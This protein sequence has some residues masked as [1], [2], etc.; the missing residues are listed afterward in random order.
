MISRLL[1]EQKLLQE[2]LH[3]QL[4]L[5]GSCERYA[6]ALLPYLGQHG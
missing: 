5:E 1:Q 4:N 2:E 6:R 3:Q